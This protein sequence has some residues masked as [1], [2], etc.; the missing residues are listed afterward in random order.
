MFFQFYQ[1]KMTS[2]EILY[3]LYVEHLYNYIDYICF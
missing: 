1:F 3:A 2:A